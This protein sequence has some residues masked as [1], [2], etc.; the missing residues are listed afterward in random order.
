MNRVSSTVPEEIVTQ[1]WVVVLAILAVSQA[2][3]CSAP[4]PPQDIV[5]RSYYRLIYHTSPFNSAPS[6]NGAVAIQVWGDNQ[7]PRYQTEAFNTGSFHGYKSPCRLEILFTGNS[8]AVT[9]A[10]WPLVPDS[11]GD[12]TGFRFTRQL[13]DGTEASTPE[14]QQL[15]E[16]F[17]VSGTPDTVLVFKFPQLITVDPLGHDLPR[18]FN[19][20]AFDGPTLRISTSLP[21]YFRPQSGSTP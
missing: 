8:A 15:F 16:S 10:S 21:I 4:P 2:C 14:G 5:F 6:V 1:R 9:S 17:F 12:S 18:G 19:G 7:I 3:G 11:S 13:G 20:I